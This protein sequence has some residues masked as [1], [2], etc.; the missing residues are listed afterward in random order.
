MNLYQ[1]RILLEEQLKQLDVTKIA[2]N[3]SMGVILEFD[4]KYSD[5]LHNFHSDYPLTPE[6]ITI[7]EDMLSEHTLQLREKMG[8]R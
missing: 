8:I 5:P 3:A 2:D 4:V 6:N 7:T 1:K